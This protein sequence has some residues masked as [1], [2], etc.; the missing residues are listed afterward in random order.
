MEQLLED[1]SF[2]ADGKKI[3]DVVVDKKFV[4]E[5]LGIDKKTKDLKKYIL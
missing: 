1:V 2:N 4:E 3:D 5:K